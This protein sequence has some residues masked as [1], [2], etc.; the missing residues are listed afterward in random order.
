MGSAAS[1]LTG[2]FW[3]GRN[4]PFHCRFFFRKGQKQ[5]LQCGR[6][7]GDGSTQREASDRR[8]KGYRNERRLAVGKLR[9]DVPV[10]PKE[11]PGRACSIRQRF[12]QQ[13]YAV[14]PPEMTLNEPQVVFR[15]K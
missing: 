13:K 12:D 8:R 3:T 6:R 15:Q 11:K 2:R 14:R 4:D 10:L 5:G 9:L 7:V 1:R